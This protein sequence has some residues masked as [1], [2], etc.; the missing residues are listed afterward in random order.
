MMP[1]C[2]NRNAT[3]VATTWVVVCGYRRIEESVSALTS[4]RCTN[5]ALKVPLKGDSILYYHLCTEYY[6]V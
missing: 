2:A 1:V 4:A 6:T 5:A 3:V